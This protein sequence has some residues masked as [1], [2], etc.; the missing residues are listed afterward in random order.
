ME[1]KILEAKGIVDYDF[2]NDILFFKV[3]NREY[4][5]SV[6]LEDIVF[7]LDTEGYV[8]GIQI[9]GASKMFFVD[10]KSLKSIDNWEFKVKIKAN[11]LSVNLLFSTSKDNKIIERG[12]NLVREASLDL[13]DSEVVCAAI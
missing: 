13:V 12:Q 4:D 5:H 1:N 10:K 2:D 11:I 6:E 8:S 3:K 7:D 9:F